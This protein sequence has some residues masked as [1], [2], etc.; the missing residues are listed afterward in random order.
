[1]SDL[2]LLELVAIATVIST[3]F[4]IRQE[5]RSGNRISFALLDVAVMLSSIGVALLLVLAGTAQAHYIG[6]KCSDEST[7]RGPVNTLE[8]CEHV[9]DVIHQVFKND[10]WAHRMQELGSCE[11]GLD[12]WAINGPH[13]GIFQFGE[14]ERDDYGWARRVLIQVRAAKRMVKARGLQP[15]RGGTCA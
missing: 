7:N 9:A 13:D 4:A 2:V 5:L 6:S 11:G 12:K 14:D 15:W 8:D 10:W 3:L 1:M